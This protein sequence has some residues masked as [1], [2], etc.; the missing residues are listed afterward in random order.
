MT[1]L[2]GLI[3]PLL[4]LAIAKLSFPKQANGSLIYKEGKVIGSSL[5]GQKFDQDKYFWPRPSAVGY[6]PLPSGG[7][8][9]GPTSSTLRD[10][11]KLRREMLIKANGKPT[12]NISSVPSDLLFSSGSGLDPHISLNAAY[13]QL[14]RVAKAR[15]LDDKAKASVKEMIERLSIHPLVHVGPDIINVLELNLALDELKV[16]P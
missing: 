6:N 9:L 7:S 13:Y 16:T 14:D 12:E 4:I 8:N 3:Y 5:I 2:T 15:N 10:E 11:V 1:A